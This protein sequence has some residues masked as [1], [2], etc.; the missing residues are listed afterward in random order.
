VTNGLVEISVVGAA[1]KKKGKKKCLD[2]KKISLGWWWL[3]SQ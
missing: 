2:K 3:V 1:L